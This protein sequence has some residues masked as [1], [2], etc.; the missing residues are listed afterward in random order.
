M[1]WIMTI[2]FLFRFEIRFTCKNA[3]DAIELLYGN[4]AIHLDRK[5]RKAEELLNV[6]C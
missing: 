3:R 1:H 4:S 2:H 5:K 6:E